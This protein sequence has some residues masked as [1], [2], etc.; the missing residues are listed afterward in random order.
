VELDLYNVLIIVVIM[1]FA[2]L[3]LAYVPVM[4]L[5]LDRI[6]EPDSYSALI[7]VVIMDFVILK[8]V[9]VHVMK[10]ILD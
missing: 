2:I 3:K 10:I 1:E 9:F 6:V 4:S 7:I 8:L 5:G